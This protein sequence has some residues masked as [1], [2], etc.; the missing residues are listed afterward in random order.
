MST[1]TITAILDRYCVPYLI[2]NGRV[3]ADSME[4]FKPLFSDVIDVTNYNRDQ[5]YAW[6]GY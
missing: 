5:L 1:K 4:A 6:L 2:Q 3:L